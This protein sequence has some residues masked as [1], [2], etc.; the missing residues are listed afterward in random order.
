L[1]KKKLKDVDKI[2]SILNSTDKKNKNRFSLLLVLSI[3][4][5]ISTN[6]FIPLL[7][8]TVDKLTQGS[9]NKIAIVSDEV[10]IGMLEGIRDNISTI[11]LFYAVIILLSL[12]WALRVF[13]VVMEAKF[14]TTLEIDFGQKILENYLKKSVS[15]FVENNS[16][17]LA[18]DIGSEAYHVVANTYSPILS[19]FKVFVTL[20]IMTIVLAVINLE[21]MIITATVLFFLFYFANITA[22]RALT[23]LGAERIHQNARRHKVL[24][25]ISNLIEDIKIRNIEKYFSQKYSCHAKSYARSQAWAKVIAQISRP[26]VEIT[27][28]LMG[29]V[30]FFIDIGGTTERVVE[31]T[32]AE[33]VVFTFAFARFIPFYQQIYGGLAQIRYIQPALQNLLIRSASEKMK[34]DQK[35]IEKIPITFT[36]KI[37]FDRVHLTYPNTHSEVLSDIS[38]EITKNAVVGISGSSGSGK[39]SLIKILLGFISPSKGRLIIDGGER[40]LVDNIDWFSKVSF[41]SQSPAIMEASVAE[42]VALGQNIEELDEVRV[43][44]FLSVVGMLDFVETKM[45]KG[46]WTQLREGGGNLSGGQKQRLALARALYAKPEILVLDEPTSALDARNAERILTIINKI[47]K[48]TTV[49]IISHDPRMLSICDYV[50]NVENTNFL[51]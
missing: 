41:L 47:R 30:I 42:N 45:G 36:K 31:I 27:I 11:Q 35:N 19:M 37:K 6:S 28:V 23:N 38:L 18:K 1:I 15:W 13:Y 20:L 10:Q 14:I 5:A 9:N 25:E 8:I 39:T 17:D 34:F 29:C 40:V 7:F 22:R 26:I 43:R 51:S 12:S 16:F 50:Y 2:N 44:H 48:S 46:I 21:L 49:I 4:Q 24:G 32:I 33:L 3:F